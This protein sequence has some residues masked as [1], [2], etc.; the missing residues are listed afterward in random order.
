MTDQIPVAVID[1]L[2]A[3]MLQRIGEGA[4]DNRLLAILGGIAIAKSKAAIGIATNIDHLD[5]IDGQGAAAILIDH[6]EFGLA[7]C[8]AIDR[9]QIG[10]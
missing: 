6:I 5:A 8:I 10:L 7:R 2:C 9:K 1:A 4:A 3:A